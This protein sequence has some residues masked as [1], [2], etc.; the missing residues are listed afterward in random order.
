MENEK[1][2]AKKIKKCAKK[3]QEPEGIPAMIGELSKLK[4]ENAIT[5]E[6]FEEKKK[7]LLDR[8]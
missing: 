3:T 4:D 8:L 6:E 5:L 7:E 2:V 1:E